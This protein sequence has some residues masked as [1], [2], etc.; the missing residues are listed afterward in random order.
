MKNRSAFL[1]GISLFCCFCLLIAG[2]AVGKELRSGILVWWILLAEIIA[3]LVPTLMIILPLRRGEQIKIPTSRKRLRGSTV[4]FAVRLGIAVS[5]L[6]FL[7]NFLVLQIAGDNISALNPA[8]FQASDLSGHPLVY[9]LAVALVPA[10]VEE[11]YLRG[12]VFQ[13]FSRYAGTGLCIFLTALVFAMLHGSLYHFIG[14]LL[15]GLVFGWLVFAY[16]SIWPAV[17]AHAANNLFY[18]F[19]L[20]M[21]DTYSAFGIWNYFPALCVLL[22]LLFVYLSLR[23]AERLLLAG[24]VPHFV[25]GQGAAAAIRAMIGNPAAIAFLIAFFAKTVFG[26][27]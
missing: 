5:L 13:V 7:V 8:S 2:G 19:A 4:R 14:P 3:F 12:A 9:I 6:S 18:L 11:I 20:W 17:I 27:I 1:T 10:V 25:Q 21:T 16:G 23:A 22:L 24:R 26:V 15:G